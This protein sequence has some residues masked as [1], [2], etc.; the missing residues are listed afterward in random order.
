MRSN[1]VISHA[2]RRFSVVWHTKA[3]IKYKQIPSLRLGSEIFVLQDIL[4]HLG[5]ETD[6]CMNILTENLMSS[7]GSQRVSLRKTAVH[8]LQIYLRFSNDVQSVLRYHNKCIERNSNHTKCFYFRTF[9][10][11]YTDVC[12]PSGAVAS[13]RPRVRTLYGSNFSHVIRLDGQVHRD[14][15]PRE[16]RPAGGARDSHQ[17]PHPLPG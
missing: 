2:R 15:R 5:P 16:R 14:P 12:C 1:C 11:Y 4:P 10:I 9:H 17:Y 6:A 3:S 7:L 8:I 13:W